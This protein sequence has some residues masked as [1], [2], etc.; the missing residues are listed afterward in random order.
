[1]NGIGTV[2]N[3]IY[4][5]KKYL[6]AMGVATPGTCTKLINPYCKNGADVKRRKNE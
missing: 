1:M 6:S 4:C 3:Q 5:W 2:L